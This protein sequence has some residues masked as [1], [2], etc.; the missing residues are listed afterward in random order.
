LTSR[1]A[2]QQQVGVQ[3]FREQQALRAMMT[4]N[5]ASEP[6]RACL[7]DESHKLAP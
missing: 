5:V 7:H 2:V 3:G 1:Y 6:R 4:R